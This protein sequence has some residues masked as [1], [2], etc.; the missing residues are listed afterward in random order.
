MK[1][2]INHAREMTESIISAVTN[3][4]GGSLAW[5]ECF[6]DVSSQELRDHVEMGLRAMKTYELRKFTGLHYGTFLEWKD[7][8][9]LWWLMNS[10]EPQHRLLAML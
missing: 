4:G 9:W 3:G 7:E 6:G 8:G 2:V 1:S 10:I 5:W